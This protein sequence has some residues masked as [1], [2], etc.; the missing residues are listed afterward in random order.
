MNDQQVEEIIRQLKRLNGEVRGLG[1][2][3]FVL[4]LAA[5]FFL[6]VR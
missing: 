3:H 6:F 2:I 1:V 4:F 5:L